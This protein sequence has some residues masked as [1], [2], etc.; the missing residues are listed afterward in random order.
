MEQEAYAMHSVL[1]LNE[2][3]DWNVTNVCGLVCVDHGVAESPMCD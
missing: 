3:E 2:D 1:F